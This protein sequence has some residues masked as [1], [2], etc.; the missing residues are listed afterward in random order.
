MGRFWG[1]PLKIHVVGG[2]YSLLLHNKLPPILVALNNKHL[3]SHSFCGCRIQP[4]QAGYLWF[5]VFHEVAVKL[6]SRTVVSSEG[7]TRKGSTSKFRLWLTV[8]FNSS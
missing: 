7:L 3:L 2:K 4:S 8:K 6:S 5:Q 1:F